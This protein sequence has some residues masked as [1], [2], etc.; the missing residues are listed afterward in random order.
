MK[1]FKEQKACL[2]KQGF[3]LI[4]LLVVI[5]IIGILASIVLAS[6]NTARNKGR[7]VSASASMSQMRAQGELTFD[8]DGDYTNVCADVAALITAAEN[9]V[10]GSV[11]CSVNAT[12]DAW[13]AFVTLNNANIYC[14]DSTGFSGVPASVPAAGATVCP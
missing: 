9:N 7:D 2:H 14:V 3:T 11:D 12:F 13:A 5:A 1:L 6:L 10:P 8:D 4:E